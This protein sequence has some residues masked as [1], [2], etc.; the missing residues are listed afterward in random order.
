MSVRYNDLIALLTK[1]IQEQQVIIDTQNSK[2]EAQATETTQQNITIE[3]LLLR[4][5]ALEATNN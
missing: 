3:S 2:I 5:T 4:M 1:A